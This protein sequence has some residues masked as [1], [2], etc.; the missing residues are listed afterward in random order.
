M[1]RL[2][3]RWAVILLAGAV[4]SVLVTQNY[5]AHIRPITPEQLLTETPSGSV[6]VIGMV[7]PGSL[8]IDPGVDPST[9]LRASFV[10][11]GQEEELTVE[12]AGPDDDNLRE[13]KTLVV[14]GRHRA[15]GQ[16]FE[17]NELGIIPNFSFI[18]W[19]YLLTLLPLIIFLFGMEQR[20]ALLYTVIK[21]TTVYRPENGA[22]EG[23]KEN[24][25]E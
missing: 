15:P 17:A 14:I 7:Q 19:A 23:T 1:T 13:L 18:T 4:L 5:R 3:L 16:P 12:Y 20:V 22:E 6:R 8:T 21:E 9:E 25:G 24:I 2:Y 10:L 11:T